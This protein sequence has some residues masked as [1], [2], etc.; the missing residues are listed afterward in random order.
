MAPIGIG[1]TTDGLKLKLM[2]GL[3]TVLTI[4]RPEVKMEIGIYSKEKIY[5][6]L[7]PY[8]VTYYD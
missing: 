1:A 8:L 6:R 2:K 3:I 5:E 4:I 7:K